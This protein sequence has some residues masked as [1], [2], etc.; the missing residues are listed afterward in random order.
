MSTREKNDLK[1]EVLTD[2]GLDV[3]DRYGVAFT[4]NDDIKK[5]YAKMGVD[6]DNMNGNPQKERKGKLPLPATFVLDKDGKVVYSFVD[7]D[8]TKRAEPARI[9]D[10]I[11]SVV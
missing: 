5:L 9:I 6:L 1:F 2:D 7:V 11:K 10:A 4:V 8:Y 3:A